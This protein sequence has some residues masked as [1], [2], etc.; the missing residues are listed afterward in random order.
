MEFDSSCFQPCADFNSSYMRALLVKQPSTAMFPAWDEAAWVHISSSGDVPLEPS[1]PRRVLETKGSQ[2][3]LLPPLP[4]FA[5]I[6]PGAVLAELLLPS[7]VP[8]WR[9]ELPH[10]CKGTQFLLDLHASRNV[11]KAQLSNVRETREGRLRVSCLGWLAGEGADRQLCYLSSDLA[12]FL[13]CV[14]ISFVRGAGKRW[15]GT[16]SLD[17][18]K[19]SPNQTVNQIQ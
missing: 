15:Q 16:F 8:L 19:L 10:P 11:L 13:N 1:V 7:P 12:E 2:A 18:F 9:Q 5:L 17:K 14:K 6:T 4:P 3:P